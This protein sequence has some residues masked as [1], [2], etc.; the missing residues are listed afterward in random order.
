MHKKY[1]TKKSWG[2]AR[3]GL[4]F[5]ALAKR[6]IMPHEIQGAISICLE[7]KSVKFQERRSVTPLAELLGPMVEIHADGSVDFIHPTARES[8][9]LR[10]QFDHDAYRFQLPT[11]R[12]QPSFH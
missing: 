2:R 6:S 5:L 10:D 3:L 11:P 8:V 1:V 9:P 4:D 12:T 7:T